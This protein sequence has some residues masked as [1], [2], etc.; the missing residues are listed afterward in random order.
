MKLEGNTCQPCSNVTFGKD[1]RLSCSCQVSSTKSCDVTTGG[2]VCSEGWTSSDCSRDI[3]ECTE[4]LGR[5]CQSPDKQCFNRPGGYDCIDKP[6]PIVQTPK[7][8]IFTFT[9]SSGIIQSPNYPQRYS[10]TTSCSWTIKAESGK[11]IS[12]RISSIDISSSDTYRVWCYYG[13]LGIYDGSNSTAKLLGRFCGYYNTYPRSIQSSDSTMFLVFNTPGRW[14]GSYSVNDYQVSRYDLTVASGDVTSPQYP[15][16]SSSNVYVTWTITVAA[17]N[18]VTLNFAD[19]G[20]GECG[21]DYIEVFDGKHSGCNLIARFCDSQQPKTVTST[22]RSMHIIY[23]SLGNTAEKGF[24]ASYVTDACKCYKPQT[25]SCSSPTGPCVCNPGY[26]G[27]DCSNDV[28]ECLQNPCPA[29]SR[30]INSFG[31][32]YCYCWNG[33]RVEATAT[34]D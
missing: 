24:K 34:C 16:G 29:H 6:K 5:V 4:L 18:L 1:C 9:N 13:A 32:F 30:C 21:K 7:E 27:I 25:Q 10:D 11:T 26:N 8:C 31:S 15:T 20:L 28:N 17:G 19:Y 14:S 33:T 3:N 23:S 12:L 22:E 2:C